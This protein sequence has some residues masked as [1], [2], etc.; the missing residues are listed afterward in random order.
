MLE[1]N[2]I[3]FLSEFF[4]LIQLLLLWFFIA[5]HAPLSLTLQYTK[6]SVVISTCC[7]S[8]AQKFAIRHNISCFSFILLWQ[9]A[10]L[11]RPW[12]EIFSNQC[13]YFLQ[14]NFFLLFFVFFP[15][16]IDTI[17]SHVD[18]PLTMLFFVLYIFLLH[19]IQ[20]MCV[21]QEAIII[22]FLELILL[23]LDAI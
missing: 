2:N 11:W 20:A 12:T 4:P 9:N 5:C 13:P 10:S 23:E 18:V 21:L 14:T 7:V 8:E 16:G 22:L 3:L 15:T 17:L 19:P 1:T 6:I